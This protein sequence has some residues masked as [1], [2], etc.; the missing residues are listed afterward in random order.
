[1]NTLVVFD[2][3]RGGTEQIAQVIVSTLS[4]Y[5]KVQAV[6]VIKTNGLDL[7]CGN[8]DCGWSRTA[9]EAL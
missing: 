1:M 7:R 5:G 8:G 3:R 6:D 2:S 4:H 9:P